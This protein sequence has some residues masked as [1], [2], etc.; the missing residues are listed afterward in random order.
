[1][2]LGIAIARTTENA[3]RQQDVTATRHGDERKGAKTGAARILFS[4]PRDGEREQVGDADA[5]QIR[6]Y[7]PPIN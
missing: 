3:P 5:Q 4:I 1:M 2:R 7:L 6:A